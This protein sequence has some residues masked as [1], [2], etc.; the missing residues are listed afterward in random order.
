MENK[1][2]N[3]P[4]RIDFNTQNVFIEKVKNKINDIRPDNK[5]PSY[6]VRNFGCQMNQNEAEKYTGMLEMMGFINAGN[7]EN[8]DFV[9]FN[10]CC[11]REN[12][13][14]KVFGHLGELKGMKNQKP[15]MIIAVCG[16]MMQQ[17]HTVE[18]IR[19]KYKHVNLVLGT[20]N[21]HELP[22]LL[23]DNMT[24][25]IRAVNVYE[26]EMYIP[27]GIPLK[28]E[29]QHKSWLSIIYGCNNFCSYCIVPHVRGRERSRDV[30]DIVQEAKALAKDGVKEITLL[31]Q[32]VNSYG[33]TLT[34][35]IDFTAL[36]YKLNE[37]KGLERIRFMTSHP[38]D[39]SETLI[40]A[41]SELDKVC[42]HLHLPL[43][44]GSD[45]VLKEM[46]RRYTKQ[47]YLDIIAYAK[48]KMPGL[49]LTTDIMVGF[50]G[51]TEDDFN[52]TMD[53]LK[54]VEFDMAFTFI[55]SIRKG[56]PAALRNDQVSEE[57]KKRRFQLLLDVQNA[58]SYKMNAVYV[59]KTVS[60][61]TEGVSKTNINT[62][63]GR[64]DTNK[65]VNFTADKDYTGQFVNV[66]ILN[67]GSWSLDGELD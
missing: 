29:H 3:S 10:T 24:G 15:W 33:K 41:M 42:K 43:Q 63:T 20:Q 46:N 39:I 62:Y 60:V 48:E 65:I 14:Q 49:G 34:V 36:L 40:V 4:E 1:K 58:I 31:G 21:I 47:K 7:I 61:L 37:V 27:E 19:N 23:Y 9:L 5:I 6:F 56:T 35:P 13:E 28:R 50:P 18:E 2:I 44:S 45:K 32:N 11:V 54:K 38:K 8:A 16:C 55:Y 12:A 52:E 53:V 30:E 17:P 66:K 26:T 51:E 59:G 57:D 64:T 22:K 67:A 25:G